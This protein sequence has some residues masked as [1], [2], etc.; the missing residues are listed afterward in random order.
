MA[1]TAEDLDKAAR[2]Y[3]ETWGPAAEIMRK[4][5]AVIGLPEQAIDLVGQFGEAGAARV[6]IAIR[7][8]ADWDGLRA[9]SSEVIPAFAQVAAG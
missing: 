8:P 7:P 4:R 5:G 1:A 3:Q 6:N 9:W 2:Q